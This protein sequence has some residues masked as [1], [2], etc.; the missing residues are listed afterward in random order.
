ME[1]MPSEY[2]RIVLSRSEKIF[3]R[4]VMSTEQ[5]G[6]LF[7]GTNPAMLSNESMHILVCSDGVLF[8]KFFEGFKDTTQFG[9]IMSM[10]ID[11]LYGKATSVI[12]NRLLSNKSLVDNG[13]KLLFPTNLLYIFPA[14]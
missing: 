10:L 6:Y 13:G 12:K 3:V 2:Q 14:L 1:I 9:F 11:G 5:D 7:L 4:N 8:L